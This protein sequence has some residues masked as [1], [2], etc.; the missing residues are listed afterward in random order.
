MKKIIGLA[1]LLSFVASMGLL[2]AP[3]SY[4]P[5]E[6]KAKI[7]HLQQEKTNKEREL[8][9]KEQQVAALTQQEAT[10]KTSDEKSTIRSQIKAISADCVTLQREINGLYEELSYCEVISMTA[11]Q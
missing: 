8:S 9:Q 4:T 11:S 1:L 7:P 10:A 6:A 3:R 5:K 2:A